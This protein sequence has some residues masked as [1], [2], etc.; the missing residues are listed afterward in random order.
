MPSPVRRSARAQPPP[1]PPKPASASTPSSTS[2]LSSGKQDRKTNAAGQKSATPHSLSSEDPSEPP[3]RSQRSQPKEEDAARADDNADEV[4]GDEEDITRCI[5]GHQ[6]YPGPPLSEAFHGL[7]A[8]GDDAGG[9]FIQ[10]D[11]CSVWQHGGCVGIVEESQSPDKYYCEDCRPKLHDHHIDTKGQQYSNYLPLHPEVIRKSSAS[12]SSDNGK[13]E[14]EAANSRA[15][16]DPITGRRRATM[17]SKEHDDEE[18]EL[19]RALE[20]SQK[21]I[22][23]AGTGRR[24]GKRGRDDTEDS[25]APIK[26]QRTASDAI[27]PPSLNAEADDESD[28]E[29]TTASRAKKARADAVQSA[30]QAELRDQEKERE[31]ARADAAGRRQQRAGRRR[32]DE[33]ELL[34]ETPKPTGSERTSLPRSS[35]PPSPP[36]T[37]TAP[38]KIPQKKG[39]GKTV[40]KL[41][42]NQY[43]KQR[44]LAAQGIASSPHSKKRQ[45]AGT[46]QTSSGD[47]HQVNGGSHPTN[48]SNSTSKNSPGGPENGTQKPAGK[49]G[50]GKNKLLNGLNSHKQP[51]A[52]KDMSVADMERQMEAMLAYM[53][54][55]QVEMANEGAALGLGGSGPA[56]AAAGVTSQ[57]AVEKPF[58]EM[59]G[60]EMAP[61][62]I[63]EIEKWKR[64]HGRQAQEQAV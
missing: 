4:A 47:E 61:V 48:T 3:R 34:D 30:R 54:R 8:Q 18:E 24:N 52:V 20:E 21:E 60:M 12:K 45:L 17:R 58:E 1:P 6:E 22:E 31:R 19:R 36:P 23:G 49:A 40:K 13:K 14:R 29:N 9:L 41:G 10:C 56:Q 51:V 28:G 32:G 46:G 15:S 64:M 44:E 55:E 33:E 25:K 38:E 42:N 11:G 37:F 63:A 43:T 59:S 7:D 16:A 35:Q 53:Q 26:R 62:V 50:K 27:L 2:L 5:C 39:P 57:P